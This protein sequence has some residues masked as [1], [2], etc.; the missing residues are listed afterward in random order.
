MRRIVCQLSLEQLNQLEVRGARLKKR[1]ARVKKYYIEEMLKKQRRHEILKMMEKESERWLYLDNV[2][3]GIKNTVLIPNNIYYQ[4]DYFVKLQERAM[5]LSIGQY[6]EI[7]ESRIAHRMHQYKNSKLIPVYANLTGLLSKLRKN[8]LERLYEEYELALYGLKESGYS[9][10]EFLVKEKELGHFY[11][12][13]IMKLKKD[14]NHKS[15]K[16]KLLEEKLLLIYNVLIVWREYTGLL[17]MTF[18]EYQTLM[19]EDHQK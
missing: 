17:N 10:E 16:L 13:L 15:I 18:E 8:D 19:N 7:E 4:T 6:D 12:M 14:M 2:D 11:E 3:N 9:E 5:M 1:L